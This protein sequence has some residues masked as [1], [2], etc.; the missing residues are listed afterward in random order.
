MLDLKKRNL[1]DLKQYVFLLEEWIIKSLAVFDIRGERRAGRVGI[2]ISHQG[3]ESKIAAIGIRVSK[4]ITYHGVSINIDPDMSCYNSIIPCGIREYG[5]TS[6]AL[7]GKS[8]SMQE[9][10]KVLIQQFSK[11][12]V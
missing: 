9:L 4:W 8:C 7:L 5:V 10:D 3:I 6:F 12:F 2:W 1:M 11:I